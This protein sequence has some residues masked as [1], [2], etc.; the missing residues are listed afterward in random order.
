MFE[1]FFFKKQFAR[2]AVTCVDRILRVDSELW[3]PGG[4]RLGHKMGRDNFIQR[5]KIILLNLTGILHAF[6]KMRAS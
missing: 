4:G 5:K 3:S 1:F 2:K 6:I